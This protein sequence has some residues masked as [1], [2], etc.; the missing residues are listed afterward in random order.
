MRPWGVTV[1]SGL[2]VATDDNRLNVSTP[3]GVPLQVLKLCQMLMGAF[4]ADEGCA[5]TRSACGPRLRGRAARVGGVLGFAARVR[6][7]KHSGQ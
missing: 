5:P 3:K 4:F 6:A 2:V 7:L 1:V